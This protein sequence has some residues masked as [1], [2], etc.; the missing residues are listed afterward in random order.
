MMATDDDDDDDDDDWLMMMMTT[1]MDGNDY[2]DDEHTLFVT[3]MQYNKIIIISNKHWEL[4]FMLMIWMIVL[5]QWLNVLLNTGF[6]V[7][8]PTRLT[9]YQ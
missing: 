3:D 9:G 4:W 2:D 8:Q 1:T 7:K 6:S 5:Q